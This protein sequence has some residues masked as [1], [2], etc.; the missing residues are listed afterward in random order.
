VKLVLAVVQ[1]KDWPRLQAALT[2]QGFRVTKLSSTGGFLRQGNTTLFVG[3]EDSR[4]DS[5]IEIVRETC[6][7]REQYVDASVSGQDAD[8]PVKVVIGGATLFVVALERM[9]RI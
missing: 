2:R 8:M 9:E 4:V 3:T 1:D 7:S 5:I 6:R